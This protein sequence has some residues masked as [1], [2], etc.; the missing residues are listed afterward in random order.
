MMHEV[1]FAGFGGQGVLL[2]GR[3]L[4]YAGMLAGKEVSWFPAYG[5]EMRGGTAS[6]STIIAD[7]EIGSPIVTKPT[8]LVVMNAPSLDKFE[9]AVRPGGVL[10][11]N[12]S[13]IERQSARMD[14]QVY[15]VPMNEIATECGNI[16]F[17]NMIALG[18]LA[19]ATQIVDKSFLQ[20]VLEKQFGS[21]PGVAEANMDAATRGAQC[22]AEQSAN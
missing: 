4:A 14:I 13:L 19:G 16:R 7:G 10:I 2:A 5:P 15:Y 22:V 20:K 12:S 8:A 21:K 17:L 6:C 3:L 1:T 18:A 9:A 11:I